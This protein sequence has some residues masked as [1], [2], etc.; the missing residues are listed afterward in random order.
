MFDAAELES[1]TV[2]SVDRSRFMDILR[3]KPHLPA[4]DDVGAEGSRGDSSGLCLLEPV[5]PGASLLDEEP[6]VMKAPSES[7]RVVRGLGRICE[8]RSNRLPAD[9]ILLTL[10]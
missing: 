1:V 5:G 2:L 4:L 10:C 8:R 7:A 3:K 9:F 6:G